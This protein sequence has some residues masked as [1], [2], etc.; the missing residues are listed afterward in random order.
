MLQSVAEVEQRSMENTTSSL[1]AIMAT[2]LDGVV[3][4]DEH[5]T[6]IGWNANAEAIFGYTAVEALRQPMDELIIP[7]SSRSAHNHGMNRY[8]TTGKVH[9]L[10]SR[11][12]MTALH[13]EGHEFS[14]ELSVMITSKVGNKCFVA[15]IRDL[16]AEIAAKDKIEI[17]QNELLHLN[18]LNAM[19]T[20]A[21]MIAHEL[22]QPLAAATNYL[23]ACQRLLQNSGSQDD[24]IDLAINGVQD[25]IKT[26]AGIVKEVRA[27]VGQQPVESSPHELKSLIVNAVR[28]IDGS[29]PSRPTYN[30]GR[31]AKT[32]SVNRGEIEQVLLNLIRNA[33]EAV[34]DHSDPVII[35]SSKRAGD[36]VE[37]CI[38]D[39]G[40]GLSN[41]AQQNLFTAFK[42]GK[43]D[44]LGL[45]LS[46]CRA[47]V[48]QRGG[49][50]WVQSDSF[51]TAV[52]FTV[53]AA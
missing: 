5:G 42:S 39:N 16:T 48:E 40:T 24:N 22:N 33:V 32:V 30:F 1:A 27:I 23:S 20:A 3:A 46:I 11:V 44:G 4:T 10:G 49:N 34:K 25:A 6:V 8:L 45:G 13:K 36:M 2:S 53:A 50:I 26:A 18:R 52:T 9:I 21:A 41:T 19:G 31:S 15:F 17:L 12:K 7:A 37:V 47:I 38:R 43:E 51:G 28:L 29:L 14:V 35:C